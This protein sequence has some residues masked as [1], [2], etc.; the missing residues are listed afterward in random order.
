[1]P[2]PDVSD[3]AW[4]AIAAITAP[5]FAAIGFFLREIFNWF[6]RVRGRRKD[7]LSRVRHFKE[8]LD[9]SLYV[10]RAQRELVLRLDSLLEARSGK[11]YPEFFGDAPKFGFDTSFY[12]LY[13][14][15]NTEEKELFS[16]ISP[17]TAHSMH[18]VNTELR[19]WANENPKG[20]LGLRDRKIAERF[21]QNILQLKAHLD[22][23]FDRY[24]KIFSVSER[25]S[26]IYMDDCDVPGI[27]FPEDLDGCVN[28]VIRQLE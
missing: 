18:R 12:R 21:E 7:A 9:D 24:E 28:E 2:S 14:S 8:L 4:K 23:W 20:T 3:E 26:V 17:L 27:A 10:F 11:S 6:G 19:K 13:E 5:V 15:M 1:M 25:R 16:I 22:L